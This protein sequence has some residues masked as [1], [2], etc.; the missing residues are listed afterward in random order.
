MAHTTCT[1]IAKCSS[2]SL[3]VS[4]TTIASRLELCRQTC[5][6]LGRQDLQPD[7]IILNVSSSPYLLDAGIPDRTLLEWTADVQGLEVAWVENTG[8]YRKLL[9]TLAQLQ[10]GDIV[11]TADDDVLYGSSWLRLLVDCAQ[12]YPA[13]V[14]CG[15]ARRP[16]RNLLGLDRGYWAWPFAPA[17]IVGA[18]LVPVGIAGVAYRPELLDLEWLADTNCNSIAPT[19]DDLWF[20]EAIRRKGT[21]VRVAPGIESQIH[22]TAHASTLFDINGGGSRAW[23]N[24]TARMTRHLKSRLGIPCCVNDINYRAIRTYSMGTGNPR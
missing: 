24:V 9:P 4:L 19:T 20:A 5:E 13:A 16:G 3:I 12:S 15:R 10:T 1:S 11:V 21:M 17:G 18:G 7:R 2:M 22:P 6:A 23:G 8:P 14:V